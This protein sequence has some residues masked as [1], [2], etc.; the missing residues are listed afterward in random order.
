MIA[1]KFSMDKWS[2]FNFE[3]PKVTSI[4]NADGCNGN[5][6]GISALVEGM[7]IEEVIARLEVTT[8]GSKK[9]SALIS[10]RRR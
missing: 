4:S 6:K 1:Q 9:L 8:C 7:G 2:D 3:G 10:W 5:L